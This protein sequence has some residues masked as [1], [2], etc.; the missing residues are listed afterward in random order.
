[1][2]SLHKRLDKLRGKFD[3]GPGEPDSRRPGPT[4]RETIL[5]I[6]SVIRRLEEHERYHE[7]NPASVEVPDLERYGGET[8]SQ[9]MK[10]VN[11]LCA[12]HDAAEEEWR[13]VHR[14]DL[15]S[16]LEENSEIDK[17]LRELEEEIAE[18]EAEVRTVDNNMGEGAG[19]R[20]S[21]KGGGGYW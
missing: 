20:P 12:E 6:D 10:R 4:T 8:L 7:Q 15:P 5:A 3:S 18:V 16:W 19:G 17:R 21:D 11:Q 14:P 9:H 2:N 13:R 1:M